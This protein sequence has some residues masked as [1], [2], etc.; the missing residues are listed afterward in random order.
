MPTAQLMGAL[1]AIVDASTDAASDSTCGLGVLTT[2]PR[3][4]TLAHTTV[5][6]R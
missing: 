3:D 1:Q 2:L 6:P 5:A 4:E